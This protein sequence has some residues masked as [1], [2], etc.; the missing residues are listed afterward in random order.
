[1]R[2]D[3]SLQSDEMWWGGGHPCQFCGCYPTPSTMMV[4]MKVLT[5]VMCD[6]MIFYWSVDGFFEDDGQPSSS[7]SLYFLDFLS[8]PPRYLLPVMQAESCFGFTLNFPC[9]SRWM[10]PSENLHSNLYAKVAVKRCVRLFAF[11]FVISPIFGFGIMVSLT[12]ELVS[13]G[14]S[15]FHAASG[16]SRNPSRA[17]IWISG[18]VLALNTIISCAKLSVLDNLA[19]V[20]QNLLRCSCATSKSSNNLANRSFWLSV[21]GWSLP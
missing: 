18:C 8:V 2:W 20:L 16:S 7:E 11:S 13:S 21:R 12:L 4:M 19:W 1:M 9:T 17:F 6:G 14:R 3:A 10:V 5:K 15:A